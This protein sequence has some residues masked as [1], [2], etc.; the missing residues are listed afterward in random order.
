[1]KDVRWLVLTHLHTD[2]AGGLYHFPNTE[3][4]V[5]SKEYQV[6]LGLRGQLRG[7]LPHRWP[8]WF[9]PTLIDFS[10]SSFGP[11]PSSHVLTQ[12]GDIVLIPTLGHTHGHLSVIVHDNSLSYFIAG[13][14]SYTE[15][16]MVKQV[17]DGVA[18]N[19]SDARMTLSQIVNFVRETPTVYLPS[20]DPQS[21][22][23]LQNRVT[24][25]LS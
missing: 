1:V 5:S 19:E 11:F 7:Y 8:D 4:L 15:E 17:I 13:D 25:S 3:I 20:H 24:V 6:A 14:T 10:G 2:H 18:P 9:V 22:Q 16:L 21:Q 12:A 23:R